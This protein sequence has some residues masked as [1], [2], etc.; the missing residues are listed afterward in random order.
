MHATLPYYIVNAFTETTFGGNPAAVMVL[1]Q[2][3]PDEQMQALAM[4]HNLSETAF[5]VTQSDDTFALRWFTPVAEV[6][7]CGHAT[8]AAAHVLK[9]ELGV[10][11]HPLLFQTRFRGSLFATQEAHGIAIDLP[12]LSCRQHDVEDGVETALGAEVVSAVRPVDD[13]WQ[14]IY[15]LQSETAVREL[16]PDI[17]ALAN[18]VNHCVIVTARASET[19]F[20]SRMFAPNL[21]VDEDPVTG[22]A[23]CLLAPFWAHRLA[24]GPSLSAEQCSAR[25]GRLR[26]IVEGD[27]V[28]LVGQ[29]V[30]F[31]VGQ[32]VADALGA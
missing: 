6:P 21:G 19:D 22:S 20:V 7:L 12:A 13:P 16:Q 23:H 9:N 30:T 26:C 32:I 3:L 2:W 11:E 31:A 27:R 1:D 14:V 10:T 25:G 29:A 5:L 17:T 24:A 8:L 15:E 18:A 28:K 4:Q